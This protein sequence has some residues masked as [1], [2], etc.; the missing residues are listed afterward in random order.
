MG[1]RV[2]VVRK[3]NDVEGDVYEVF[4]KTNSYGFLFCK[5]EWDLTNVSTPLEIIH[6]VSLWVIKKV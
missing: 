3:A 6:T 4:A 5:L 1:A 2:H